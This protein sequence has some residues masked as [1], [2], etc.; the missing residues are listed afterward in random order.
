[1]KSP[2]AY[3]Y[4]RLSSKRQVS[5]DGFRRQM[6]LVDLFCKRNDLIL[7]EEISHIG[8]AFSGAN[9]K[10]GT[11]LWEFLERVKS[12]KIERGSFLL[13]ESLDRLSRD[14]VFG[15]YNTFSKIIESGIVLVTLLDNRVYS[16]EKMEKD[17]SELI[18]SIAVM[19]RAREESQ[20]KSERLRA[21]WVTKR[22]TPA[23]LTERGPS[24]L[25]Y[26]LPQ[27]DE[28]G[29]WEQIPEKVAVI[30]QI[31]FELAAGI[32]CD[33]I[34]RR[35]NNSS[36]GQ[37]AAPTLSRARSWHSGTVYK[38]IGNRIAL[39]HYQPHRMSKVVGADGSVKTKRVPD[40]PE[41]MG[42]YG[43]PIIDEG[44][45]LRALANAT[46]KRMA[47]PS[48]SG[49]RKGTIK[50]N[51]FT[52]LAVCGH[53]FNRMNYRHPG[54]RSKPRLHCSGQRNGI[55]NNNTRVIYGD[56]EDAILKA[57]VDARFDNRSGENEEAKLTTRIHE[58]TSKIEIINEKKKK[59][60]RSF[61][62]DERDEVHEILNELDAKSKPIKIDIEKLETELIALRSASR[63]EERR[64]AFS[65]MHIDLE[66]SHTDE[67]KF[68]I[69]TRISSM[70]CEMISYIICYSDGYI[71]VFA[72]SSADWK[73]DHL[74]RHRELLHDGIHGFELIP[75]GRNYRVVQWG[76]LA[77]AP[78]DLTETDCLMNPAIVR[79]S[80]NS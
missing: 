52:E 47:T 65:M 12:G 17:W 67:E 60:I 49:G 22:A 38:L 23:V 75:D 50:S 45:W 39:G 37:N 1:M 21:A 33:K 66:R 73:L 8:S 71:G 48:N 72:K 24:W 80:P 32:G 11:A 40:G 34:A 44:T 20:R 26:V 7:D 10:P 9:F 53:C 31:Y 2:K 35:L 54:P 51:L 70:L 58:L 28:P 43:P 25:R 41:R 5:G 56:L 57:A 14:N 3:S 74:S 29:R 55:C 69:R 4:L 77:M 59:L 63:H 6:E 36:Y 76:T 46:S 79:V 15:A 18:I 19:S 30:R 62:D 61:V 13:V 27:D 68:I 78:E 42:Y 16:V 64:D